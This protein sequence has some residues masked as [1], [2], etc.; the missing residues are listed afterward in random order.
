VFQF[1]PFDHAHG[2]GEVSGI[3]KPAFAVGPGFACSYPA[4]ICQPLAEPLPNQRRRQAFDL[5]VYDLAISHDSS[6]PVYN[7]RSLAVLLIW[8]SAAYD[9]GANGNRCLLEMLPG[10][11]M[12]ARE[13]KHR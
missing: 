8:I 6:S 3:L 1:G 10:S 2:G 7:L 5:S 9:V 11:V 4:T 13:M 12:I